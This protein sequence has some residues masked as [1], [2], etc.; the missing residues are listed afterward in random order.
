MYRLKKALYGLK[1]AQRAWYNRIDLYLV[2]NGFNKCD[3][4]PTLYIKENDSKILILVLYVDDLIF[5]GNDVSLIF[6]S[7][8]V[9][10]C[11]FEITDLGLLKYLLDIELK[12]TEKGIFIS[13]AKYVAEVLNRLNM[14]KNKPSSTATVMKLKL[15]KEYRN[16]NANPTLYKSR[17]AV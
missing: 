4:E 15:S 7:K 17:L 2:N 5:R 3:G 14:Q 12:Q 1:Q 9:M 16:K 8:V 13:Q 6:D 11:E 10:K